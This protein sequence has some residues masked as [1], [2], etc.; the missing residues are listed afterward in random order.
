MTLTRD[1]NNFIKSI[2]HYLKSDIVDINLTTYLFV[3]RE[4]TSS[5]LCLVC[6]NWEF[7]KGGNIREFAN[8]ADRLIKIWV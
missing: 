7:C 5:N 3:E 1:S 2:I 8:M 4:S 6:S